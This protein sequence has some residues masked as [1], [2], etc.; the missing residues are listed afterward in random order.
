MRFTLFSLRSKQRGSS[1]DE[2]KSEVVEKIA[3]LLIE[4]GCNVNDVDVNKKSPL[5][6]A[7][8]QVRHASEH[9]LKYMVNVRVINRVTLNRRTRR[10]CVSSSA[11]EVS[12]RR[13]WTTSDATSCT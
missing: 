11:T 12:C 8:E 3:K 5:M 13:S 9:Y 7:I 1:S 6:L 10:S 4:N 2:K